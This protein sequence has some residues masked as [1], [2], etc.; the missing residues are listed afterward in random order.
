M[1]SE[2]DSV[3]NHTM[4]AFVDHVLTAILIVSS[5]K[6]RGKGEGLLFEELLKKVNST[7]DPEGKKAF[8]GLQ[9]EES[10]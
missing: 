2:D 1:K 4:S 8:D 6:K 5:L 10:F 7:L 9:E 3:S